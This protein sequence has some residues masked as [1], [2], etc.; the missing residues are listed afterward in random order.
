[1]VRAFSSACFFQRCRIRRVCAF[2]SYRPDRH[3][4]AVARLVF[5]DREF[6]PLV[7]LGVLSHLFQGHLDRAFKLWIPPRAPVDWQNVN[8][9]VR[10]DANILSTPDALN[11]V[12]VS[13]VWNRHC[14]AIQQIP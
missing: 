11:V 7:L 4:V 14:T 13:P 8:L 9:Y 2:G 10:W 1:M 12:V 6:W 3:S 5:I